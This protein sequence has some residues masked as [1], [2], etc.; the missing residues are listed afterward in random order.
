MIDLKLNPS[1]QTSITFNHFN[2][3][4]L[5]SVPY[6]V[7]L[8]KFTFRLSNRIVVAIVTGFL[9]QPV[10]LN[11]SFVIQKLILYAQASCEINYFII[12]F[13]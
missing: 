13:I 11:F 4:S 3:W 7:M 8:T 1:P 12:Y 6:I 2:L 5:I 10:F 9:V